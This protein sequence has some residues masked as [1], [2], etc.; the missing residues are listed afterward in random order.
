MSFERRCSFYRHSNG[1]RLGRRIRYCDFD[2]DL[3]TCDGDIHF[4]EKSDALSKL[5]I[6]PKEKI[7]DSLSEEFSEIK[8]G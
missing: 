7:K 2:T 8:K 3:T 6:G 5:S 4:C 1:L